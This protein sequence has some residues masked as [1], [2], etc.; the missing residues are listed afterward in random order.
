MQTHR[1]QDAVSHFSHS[2]FLWTKTPALLLAISFCTMDASAFRIQP[3]KSIE[4]CQDH[5]VYF[6]H[7][8]VLRGEAVI[9]KCSSSSHGSLAFSDLS[10]NLTWHKN[11]SQPVISGE[12]KEQR[13]QAKGDT[14][15]FLPASLEDTGVYVCTQ[16]NSSYCAKVS[17]HLTV[18]EKTA[19]HAISYMQK[20][21][22]FTSG[23]LVCPD[24]EDFIDKKAD[25]ELK[26]YKDSVPLDE[27]N[28]KYIRLKETTSLIISSVLPEDSGYYT[29][30]MSFTYEGTQY[31][32]TR[33]IQ[34]QTVETEKRNTPVIVYPDQ[35]T[36]LA[37]PGYKM[38]IPCK[39][40]I[41]L[42]RDSYTIVRWLANDT[43]IDTMYKDDRVTVGEHQE[44]VENGENFIEV[45]LIFDPVREV[46]F[47]TDFKCLAQNSVGYQV[48]PTRVKEEAISFS[49]YIAMI[50]V[51]LACLLVGGLLIHKCWKQR[52]DKG[53]MIAKP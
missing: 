10:L 23:K 46:D 26:W 38:I 12:D 28:K 51:A 3:V 11:D 21:F 16:R 41:G 6:K 50:P 40:F 30:K 22:T 31:P 7:Y 8:F 47:Y 24:L 9:L 52:A 17:I 53:Y 32:V 48:L 42:S 18:V 49:W 44:I 45:P 15:W 29:C 2:H 39:V 43:N 36:T 34:L 14:L 25:L 37:V 35:K 20:L 13:I 5:T 1:F 33:T 27:D 4:Q 19:A